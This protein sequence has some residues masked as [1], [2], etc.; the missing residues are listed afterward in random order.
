MKRPIAVLLAVLMLAASFAGCSETTQQETPAANEQTRSAAEPEAIP[1]E[2]TEAFSD[3]LEER[4]FEG[5][6]YTVLYRDEDEH[7]REITAEEL[8][9]DV[10]NDAIYNRTQEIETRFNMQLGLLPVSE[11]GLNNTFTNAVT[12][13][14]RSFDVGF[15]HMILTASLAASG[16]TM[17]WYDMPHLDF[18]KPWWT[19]AV[20]ELT[21]NNVMY[22]T[23]SDYCMNTFEMTWCLIFSKEMMTNLMIEETPYDLVREGRWT[24][25]AYYNMV[26]DVSNDSDGDGK[27]TV[28]DTYGINSYGS[29][30]LASVSN[31]WW[32]CGESISKFDENG[33][34][35]YAM[36]SERTYEIFDKMYALLAENDIAWMDQTSGTKMIFWDGQALFASMMV[37]DVEVNRDK[38]LAYGLVPYPKYDELQEKYLTQVDGH[39]SVMALPV[40]LTEDDCDFVGTMIEAFSAAAYSEV[41]PAYYE[42]AMQTKFAQDETMP[43]MLEL[44]RQGRVFNFGYVYDPVINRD[45]LVNNIL[46]K[47]KEL[48]SKF[49]SNKKVTE[50]YYEKIVKDFG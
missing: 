37:R 28:K 12:A 4:D 45:V 11:G 26:K 43:L 35:Y 25:D 8:T 14:D 46:G 40:T 9:G 3:G 15:Q 1:E 27:M 42:T 29:P 32:A 7:L 50:K 49:K 23:A 5:R 31:Y 39:A 38:D 22:V 21:V 17:N 16:V 20:K 36:D 34:P 33:M 18:E 13:G 30:W 19:D 10:I 6:V 44:I 2:E 41:I 47:N 48:A 24:L